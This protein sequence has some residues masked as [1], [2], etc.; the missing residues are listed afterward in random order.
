LMPWDL[1]R[2]GSATSHLSAASLFHDEWPYR[3]GFDRL[4]SRMS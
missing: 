2:S 1:L 3:M 4:I